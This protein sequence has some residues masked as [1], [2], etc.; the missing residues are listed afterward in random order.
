MASADT[1]DDILYRMKN[2]SFE[3]KTPLEILSKTIPAHV[4]I[5]RF[6]D[7][8]SFTFYNPFTGIIHIS[9]GFEHSTYE[10]QSFFVEKLLQT[11]R[12]DEFYNSEYD[13][14]Q[15]KILY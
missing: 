13:D 7:E 3:S 11:V 5:H 14:E 6:N 8:R 1:L 10:M 2:V 9:S 15:D 12:K 4:K